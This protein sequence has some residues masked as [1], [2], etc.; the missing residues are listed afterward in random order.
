MPYFIPISIYNDYS[1][2]RYLGKTQNDIIRAHLNLL[3]LLADVDEEGQKDKLPPGNTKFTFMDSNGQVKSENFGNLSEFDLWESM[4][5][6]AKL[7]G[8]LKPVT[9]ALM[10]DTIRRV[11]D[12]QLLEEEE[13][14]LKE[15]KNML[16]STDEEESPSITISLDNYEDYKKGDYFVK[17]DKESGQ[18][19]RYKLVNILKSGNRTSMI[20]Q[21]VEGGQAESVDASYFSNSEQQVG[22]VWKTLESAQAASAEAEVRQAPENELPPHIPEI[23]DQYRGINGTTYTII[24]EQPAVNGKMYTLT[25]PESPLSNQVPSSIIDRNYTYIPK[26]I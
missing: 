24:R 21:S 8:S 13:A 11:E 1:N 20:L 26:E 23:G 9:E 2:S 14:L 5:E 25:S 3:K 16:T 12:N 4:R 6:I 10:E 22:G 19:R 17:K 15:Q 7:D 18:S